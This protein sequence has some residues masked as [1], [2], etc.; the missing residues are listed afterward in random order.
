MGTITL[1]CPG[2][3]LTKEAKRALWDPPS[4]AKYDLHCGECA[5]GGKTGDA[6]TY[7]DADGREIFEDGHAEAKGAEEPALCGPVSYAAL[8]AP[9]PESCICSWCVQDR[10]TARSVARL[11]AS[12]LR[13]RGESEKADPSG[14]PR[15]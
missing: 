11:T 5:V 2:C 15:Q 7:R 9:H 6:G 8:H 1:H 13:T 10:L 4:A 3:G 12:W 14:K